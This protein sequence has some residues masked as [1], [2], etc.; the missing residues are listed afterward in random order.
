[1]CF[2]SILIGVLDLFVGFFD[3]SSQLVFT[4]IRVVI[5]CSNEVF[6]LV[7]VVIS[8]MERNLPTTVTAAE[9]AQHPARKLF[10]RS[11]VMHHST[12][13]AP[14]NASPAPVVSV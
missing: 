6:L 1:M 3:Y 13:N 7:V 14:A 2:M 10:R 8:S 9:P 4:I 12:K 11:F 5:S